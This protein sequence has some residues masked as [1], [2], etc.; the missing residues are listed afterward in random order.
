MPLL[1]WLLWTLL[2]GSLG[3]PV[4]RATWSEGLHSVSRKQD[5]GTSPSFYHLPMFQHA[6]GPLVARELFRPVPHK[7]PLPAGLTALLLPPAEQQR[8]VQATGARAVEVWCGYD[9]LS[10]RVDRF[11]LRAWTFPSLFR[12]GTC[13]ASR[14]S[15]RYLYFHYRLT[16]CGGDSKVVGGQLV[17][18]YSLCYT[19]PAQGYVIRVVP[20]NLPI[21]CNYNR[22]HYSYQV[23]FRPQVQHTTFMKTIRSK[24]GF[25]LTVCNA[26]WEPLPPGHWFFL[27]EPVNFVAQTGAL[28]AGERLYVDSCYATRSTDPNSTPRV[29]IITNDGCMM[30]SRREGSSSR[31]LSAGGSVLRFSVDAFLFS[32]VTQVLY[33]HCSMSVGLSASFTA[34]SCNYNQAAGRW[35]ELEAP[36]SVCSCCDSICTDA[37]DSVK[38]TVSSPGWLI[39][40]R[41]E[42]RPRTFQAE[43]GREWP[44][45]E[46]KKEERLDELLKKVQTFDH[47]EKKEE[48]VSEKL[49][50]LPAEKEET[51]HDA[52]GFLIEEE[53]EEEEAG[54]QLSDDIIMSDQT[55]PGGNETAGEGVPG[56]ETGSD[57]GL[58]TNSSSFITTTNS[59]FIEYDHTR[60]H[61]SA[62]NVS[63]AVNPIVHLCPDGDEMSCSD[64][65]S[66]SKSAASGSAVSPESFTPFN[67][68]ASG[69]SSRSGSV[70][71]SRVHE[72]L[73][74]LAGTQSSTSKS[75][76]DP[77]GFLEVMKAGQ[78]R[79]ESEELDPL[80]RSE[81]FKSAQKS[82]DT[83]SDRMPGQGVSVN[84]KGADG[85][86]DDIMLH[87]LQIRGLE[88]DQSAHA[89]GLWDLVSV[90]ESGSDSGFAEGEALHL[91]PFT[92]AVK[93]KEEAQG[94]TDSVMRHHHVR[95]GSASSEHHENTVH[96]AV[97][98]V[99]S[100]LQGSDSSQVADREWA[101]VVPGQRSGFEVELRHQLM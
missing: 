16:E 22:F 33:L 101:E 62:A 36:P 7:W 66:G 84:S 35:E 79:L 55:T 18:T 69:G 31:F 49:S 81:L 28:L 30:D 17:Y 78:S 52:A 56:T 90:E 12:L 57:S 67:A 65:N 82:V 48:S 86:D 40:H 47:E 83:K 10:V 46:E 44:D 76:F 9:K 68:R 75:G 93:T 59:S 3:S 72:G 94:F 11:Q 15:P 99:T 100:T 92:G 73:E 60:R 6:L 34:K 71:D 13:E 5:G 32:A 51:R 29:D 53:E 45:Q 89:A 2:C 85:D 96:S 38:N 8:S 91:S 43:E 39:G 97:V 64:T 14:V 42:E 58:S 24:H 19:P 26:Q 98:M 37:Q 27:G 20:L 88:S 80:L 54:G 95:P 23:G 61:G 63:K 21:H 70:Q 87:S 77:P 4:Q 74:T 41:G 25:S 1:A 50:V